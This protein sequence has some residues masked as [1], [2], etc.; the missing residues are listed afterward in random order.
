MANLPEEYVDVKSIHHR[1]EH[2]T[3]TPADKTQQERILEE[4]T[5]VLTKSRKVP[6]TPG[7]RHQ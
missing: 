5:Y 1:V 7:I 3:R 4:L 6:H 2:R